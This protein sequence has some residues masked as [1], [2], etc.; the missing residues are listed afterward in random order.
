MAITLPITS[1]ASSDDLDF[2]DCYGNDAQLVTEIDDRDGNYQTIRAGGNAYPASSAATLYFRASGATL[3]ANSG[4][5]AEI[6]MDL[7]Y[8]DDADYTIA[9]KTQKLRL[10]AQQV[11]AAVPPG[12]TLTVGL[13]PVTA[14]TA[15]TFTI[16]AV[17]SGSTV[18]FVSTAASTMAQG[19][20]GDFTVPADGYYAFG[21]AS[22]GTTAVSSDNTLHYQLQTRWV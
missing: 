14:I 9:S 2:A 8:F 12:T 1:R 7:L 22:S 3:V 11:T 17:V 6:N 16:G 13:Y 10:R 5:M 18:A 19:N 20:S 21:V 15:T 4:D